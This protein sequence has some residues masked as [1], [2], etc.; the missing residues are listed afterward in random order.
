MDLVD[1]SVP[2]LFD[3]NAYTWEDNQVTQVSFQGDRCKQE[4]CIVTGKETLKLPPG[5]DIYRGLFTIEYQENDLRRSLSF[6]IPYDVEVETADSI[7]ISV[8]EAE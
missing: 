6:R 8:P 7:T 1:I 2:F 5:T 3:T 4:K